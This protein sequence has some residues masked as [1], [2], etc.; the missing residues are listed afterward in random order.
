[1]ASVVPLLLRFARKLLKFVVGVSLLWLTLACGLFA[2]LS[3]SSL[4]WFI[5]GDFSW[6][7]VIYFFD[8]ALIVFC[9]TPLI[10][11]MGLRM[12]G[13]RTPHPLLYA[14]FAIPASGVAVVVLMLSNLGYGET[15]YVYTALIFVI[16]SIFCGVVYALW[17]VK[18]EPYRRR[19]NV[20]WFLSLL[21]VWLLFVLPW[22][23]FIFSQLSPNQRH[24]LENAAFG[25]SLEAA[26]SFVRTCQPF[27]SRYGQLSSLE[28]DGGFASYDAAQDSVDGW[29]YTLSFDAERDEGRINIDAPEGAAGFRVDEEYFCSTY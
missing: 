5:H 11:L 10:F 19:R 28:L 15:T 9:L 26:K 18:P 24:R 25:P 20:F 12:F 2:F 4:R 13:L 17:R 8:N 29:S 27:I 6:R 21:T 23:H 7:T 1:M 3:T 14:V 22:Q 16:I